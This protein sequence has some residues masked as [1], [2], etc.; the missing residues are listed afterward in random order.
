MSEIKIGEYVRNESGYIHKID[1]VDKLTNFYIDE[2]NNIREWVGETVLGDVVSE[3]IVKHSKNIIDLIEIGDY[4]N[5]IEV[6]KGKV[7]SGKEKLLVRNNIINSMSLEVV[8]IRTILTHEMHEQ[9]CYK[10][11]G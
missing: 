3:K 4:V 10:V 7:T 9:N 2:E 6:Y 1:S 8:K 5:G 11:E